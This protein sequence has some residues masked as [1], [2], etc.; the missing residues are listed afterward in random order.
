MLWSTAGCQ[1]AEVA[2]EPAEAVAP[3]TSVDTPAGT[4][5]SRRSFS[6]EPLYAIRPDRCSDR[7]FPKLA[8]PWIVWCNASTGEVDRA[9]AL[10]LPGRPTRELQAPVRDPSVA[11]GWLY[12]PSLEPRLW[13]L[14]AGEGAL[15]PESPSGRLQETDG[16]RVVT[17]GVTAAWLNRESVEVWK[18]GEATRQVYPAHPVAG[19]APALGGGTVAWVERTD[20]ETQ[21]WG[22]VGGKPAAIAAPEG[23]ARLVV[24]SG[25]WLAW[26]ERGQVVLYAPES[27]ERRQHAAVTGFDHP[28]SL[29]GAVACWEDRHGV[30]EAGEAGEGGGGDIE[31]RCSDGLELRRP[32]HQRQ[33]SRFGPWLL[34]R[35]GDSLFLASAPPNETP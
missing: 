24:G 9:T 3:P 16:G 31:I 35:E 15:A 33:P 14:I 17:D 26:V 6:V 30:R 10:D 27:G 18:L 23:G 2:A 19:S 29:D 28:P 11:P 12:R 34:F 13:R 4:S 7:R 21:I 1:G 8:G 5:P 25:A 32:G 22:L 20:D